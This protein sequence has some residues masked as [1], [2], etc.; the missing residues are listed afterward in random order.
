ML[1]FTGG[2]LDGLERATGAVSVPKML[3]ADTIDGEFDI[4]L[5]AK[6]GRW[7]YSLVHSHANLFDTA[8]VCYYLFDGYVV[9][10]QSSTD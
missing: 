7:V 1:V 3:T 8:Q 4:D 10:D 6:R 9:K 2:P 5:S